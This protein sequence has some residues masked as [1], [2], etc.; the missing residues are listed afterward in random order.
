MLT[1]VKDIIRISSANSTKNV[2]KVINISIKL[3]STKN[4]P[5][6]FLNIYLLFFFIIFVIFLYYINI[7]LK[8]FNP[9]FHYSI[10]K[11]IK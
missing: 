4:N 7:F 8:I 3:F 10:I 5:F 9:Y 2:F 11:F 6:F 1:F